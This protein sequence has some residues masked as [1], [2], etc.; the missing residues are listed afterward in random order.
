MTEVARRRP[1]RR[2]AAAARPRRSVVWLRRVTAALLALLLVWLAACFLL[3]VHP[4]TNRPVHSDAILVLGSPTVDG[5]AE[6]GVRLAEAGYADT[7]VISIGWAKGRQRVPA[8][9]DDNP[10]YRVI[11]FQPDPTTTRGEAEELGRLAQQRHWNSVL[12]VTS[13]YHVSRARLVVDRCMPGTVRMVATA[14][15]PSL[16][17]WAYQ[18][19][20]QTGGF[21]KALLHRS[22]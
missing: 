3:V 2:R 20:Y 6:E 12:V 1:G 19:L 14:A 4:R 17:G 9:A 13:V 15:R 10:R 21:G 5:R 16:R 11:C 8:C 7:L 18:F 22:C